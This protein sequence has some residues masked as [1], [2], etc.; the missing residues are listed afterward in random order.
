MRR[1][2]CPA[3]AG[4]DVTATN[5]LLARFPEV[6][7]D[8]HPT[9][10]EPLA[11]RDVVPGSNKPVWWQCTAGHEWRTS[12]GLR[13]GQRNGCPACHGATRPGHG[14]VRD[15]ALKAE[16]ARWRR[17]NP[18][19]H[20]AA[21]AFRAR[22]ELFDVKRIVEDCGIQPD[23][24]AA[25]L[26]HPRN[27][28]RRLTVRCSFCNKWTKFRPREIERAFVRRWS[29]GRPFEIA[30]SDRGCMG[31]SHSATTTARRPAAVSRRE[32]MFVE[33]FQRFYREHQRWPEIG[34]FRASADCPEPTN[35][36]ERGCRNFAELRDIAADA[37]GVQRHPRLRANLNPVV[38]AWER[39][40]IAVLRACY[41][42][43]NG[44]EF[45]SQWTLP[46]GRRPDAVVV[47]IG[48]SHAFDLKTS[49]DGSDPGIEAQVRG[50]FEHVTLVTLVVL[51]G[52]GQGSRYLARL[53]ETFGASLQVWEPADLL[54]HS[55][56]RLSSED[57]E[58][59]ELLAGLE[60]APDGEAFLRWA[61]LFTLEAALGQL[62]S[63][64]EVLGRSP[65]KGD[66]TPRFCR[67]FGFMSSQH[68]T[69][70]VK[71]QVSDSS[72]PRSRG[73]PALWAWLLT[74]AG[75]LD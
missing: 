2:D 30:C 45:R 22:P 62:R 70:L 69:N 68:M 20:P 16:T 51:R 27:R 13:T 33:C 23:D 26:V 74:N 47:E 32:E 66:F 25:L 31:R 54:R 24:D 43:R 41:E 15:Q 67:E 12:P 72:F 42:G 65:R 37:L 59:S 56:T 57:R 50:F 1:S 39:L 53:R 10:N 55:R 60:S 17:E 18:G 44:T 14:S 52:E 36:R 9:R 34:E 75:L 8:W 21:A 29:E 3:C 7:A 58:G 38:Q 11:P 40:G 4:H 35:L 28:R 64:A 48:L 71:R 49:I 63:A 5:N 19:R 73:K 61:G 6:A 46:N